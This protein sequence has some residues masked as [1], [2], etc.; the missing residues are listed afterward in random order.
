MPSVHRIMVPRTTNG[1]LWGSKAFGSS[2]RPF[3]GP[4][5]ITP[6]KAPMPP[7]MCTIIDPAKSVMPM[8]ARGSASIQ[9]LKS[10]W[11][12][13]FKIMKIYE[14]SVGAQRRTKMSFMLP[15]VW[16]VIKQLSRRKRDS[17]KMIQNC[18]TCQYHNIHIPI[19]PGR[20]RG[21]S[22]R[23]EK[24]YKPKQRVCK[25]IFLCP[26]A[27][28]PSVWWWCLV[29]FGGGWLCCH[30]V[31]VVVWCAAMRYA[32]MSCGWFGDWMK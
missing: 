2:K 25:P 26:P 24:I 16:Q 14:D 7:V 20:A 4:K 8:P 19:L 15:H 10:E 9:G 18:Q 6:L 32:M 13:R 22:F 12:S 5:T 23:V 30:G 28:S 21:G 29:V 27:F 1:R 17:N 11:P 31:S 3:R